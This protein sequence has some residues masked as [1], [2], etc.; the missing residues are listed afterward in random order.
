[1]LPSVS[2]V[3]AF[4]ALTLAL[5]L[6]CVTPAPAAEGCPPYWTFA[7]AV[8]LAAALVGGIVDVR[9]VIVL[10]A[11]AAACRA[12][13]RAERPV[14]RVV[15]HVVM[16]LLCGGL[17]LHVLP[18]FNN[19]I[20]ISQVVLGPGGAPYTKYLNFD[21]AVAA[22]FLLGLYAPDVIARRTRPSNA[23]RY[24]RAFAWRFAVL[25]LVVVACSLAVGFVRWDPKV[26]SW[27]PLW[28]WSM[29][30]LTALPE[31]A[32]FRGVV[33]TAVAR[34][35]GGMRH[36]TVIAILIAGLLFGLAHAA[37]GAV[38]VGLAS[39]AGFGYGWI[40]ASFRSLRAAILAHFGLNVI[41]FLLFTYPALA[42]HG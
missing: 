20:V 17:M 31:E 5:V 15:A 16:L 7:F 4:A 26:P 13:G 36:A 8:A 37:G 19:P 1:L 18:G 2:L 41:H 28:A 40:Y 30:F 35:L 33:Q 10:L 42:L 27:F 25:V 34:R 32:L 23:G 29:L 9:G 12:A 24:A 39:A 21:K 11:Y 22:L 6:L 38:Y 3:F 14:T